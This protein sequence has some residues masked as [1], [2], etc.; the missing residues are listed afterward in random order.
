MADEIVPQAGD[1]WERADG[2]RRFMTKNKGELTWRDIQDD[3][4][5]F[6]DDPDWFA[7]AKRVFPPAQPAAPGDVIPVE[8]AV[9]RRNDEDGKLDYIGIYGQSICDAKTFA[10]SMRPDPHIA[11]VTINVP[12]S[13]L[14]P[15]VLPN[16]TASEETPT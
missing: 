4:W 3:Y 7:T 14:S 1:V 5:F 12:K 8:C 10:Y 15:A 16:V 2:E 13:L 9:T 6:T 11:T